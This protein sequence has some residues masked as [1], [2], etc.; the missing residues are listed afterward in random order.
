MLTVPHATLWQR[1]LLD[2]RVIHY[3]I[4]K[5]S[6]R[7]V[8]SMAE[9]PHHRLVEGVSTASGR[10]RLNVRSTEQYDYLVHTSWLAPLICKLHLH[11]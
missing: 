7:C 1:L 2:A 11:V 9:P 8:T 4:F 3:T 10:I 6:A 5:A